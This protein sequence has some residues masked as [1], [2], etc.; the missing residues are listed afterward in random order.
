[1][2]ET[3]VGA[4]IKVKGNDM[5]VQLS[6]NRTVTFRSNMLKLA[7]GDRAPDDLVQAWERADI[8]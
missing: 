3:T 2:T 1:M 5:T 6:N 4:V 7:V 8:Q